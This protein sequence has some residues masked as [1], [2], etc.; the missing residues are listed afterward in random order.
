MIF[1]KP[2]LVVSLLA[3]LA[4][5]PGK[6][7][8]VITADDMFNRPGEYYL[9]YSNE[10]DPSNSSPTPFSTSNGTLQGSTGPGQIWDFSKGPTNVIYRFDYLSPTN[11]D[12]SITT[13]F[14]Q[15][16]IV[17]RQTDQSSGDVQYLFFEQIPDVGRRVYGVYANLPLFTEPSDLFTPAIIDFPARIAFGDKWSTTTTFPNTAGL[18]EDPTDPEGGGFSIDVTVTQT[19]DLEADASGTIVLPD[20]GFGDGLRVNEAVTVNVQYL[21]ETSGT[22]QPLETDYARNF[23]WLMPGRGIVAVLASTQNSGVL[24]GVAG[25]P[26]NNFPTATQFR[27]M[28]ETNKKPGVPTTG[29]TTPDPVR[30]FRIRY[31]NGQVLLSWAKANCGSQYRVEYSTNAF[32]STSWKVLGTPLT[33]QFLSL[34]NTRLD[35][36]RFYRIVTV[37]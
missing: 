26:P 30:D 29:C 28:F 1:M 18:A 11:V 34:D 31:N 6:A 15:A 33:N 14:P 20:G 12:S 3:V 5:F 37:K 2:Q 13:E 19:S 17:E 25:L 36:Q 24:G 21:D 22:Y 27:R 35:Q 23:Y 32:D 4:S 8:V 9:A 10:F 16:T 7:D